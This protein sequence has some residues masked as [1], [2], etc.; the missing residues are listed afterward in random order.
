MKKYIISIL[1][2]ALSFNVYAQSNTY[3]LLCKNECANLFGEIDK[4]VSQK[5]HGLSPDDILMQ[6]E[7]FF[8][9]DLFIQFDSGI[10]VNSTTYKDYLSQKAN[11]VSQK[12]S[13][14][15][16]LIDVKF[17]SKSVPTPILTPR[18]GA[19]SCEY[20]RDYDC[21][22]WG[23]YSG[24][25][26]PYIIAVQ[27]QVYNYEWG[28]TLTQEDINSINLTSRIRYS[29]AVGVIT[30]SPAARFTSILQ[31]GLKNITSENM[32]SLLIAAGIANVVVNEIF[33]GPRKTSLKVGDV[34]MFKGGKLVSVARDGV[35]YN[36]TT[37]MGPIGNE[38]GSG[39]SSGEGYAEGSVLRGGGVVRI[40]N[41]SFCYRTFSNG[42]VIQVPCP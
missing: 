21:E 13:S 29:F 32:V 41:I 40:P 8:Q 39:G 25:Y 3:E 7:P 4:M 28:Y 24:V 27:N 42:Q 9:D 15:F 19:L 36:A 2:V 30:F 22:A 23:D 16:D 34:V 6:F 14:D 33:N 18:D 37:I 35:I 12:S 17:S 11:L 38:G 10:A 26:K 20:D 1:L 31:A 5:N